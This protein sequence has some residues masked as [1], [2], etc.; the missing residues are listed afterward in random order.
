[1]YPNSKKTYAELYKERYD[2]LKPYWEGK[3]ITFT[4]PEDDRVTTGTIS[5]VG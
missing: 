3:K 4:L 2:A 1:L 5:F